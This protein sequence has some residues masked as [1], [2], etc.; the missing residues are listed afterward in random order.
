MPLRPS[1]RDD[2]TFFVLEF[3]S[4]A[5]IYNMNHEQIDQSLLLLLFQIHKRICAMMQS[6]E[7]PDALNIVLDSRHLIFGEQMSESAKTKE[8]E[9]D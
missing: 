7:K 3:S 5:I 1:K 6:L 2:E 4:G 9:S 8:R